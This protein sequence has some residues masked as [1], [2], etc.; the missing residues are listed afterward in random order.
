MLAGIMQYYCIAYK[1]INAHRCYRNGR[2][3][4]DSLVVGKSSEEE[5]ERPK[6]K[7]R[8]CCSLTLL[9]EVKNEGDGVC[10]N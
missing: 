2:H 10:E 8:K 6:A 5:E 9:F 7:S 4:E 3:Q 1:E